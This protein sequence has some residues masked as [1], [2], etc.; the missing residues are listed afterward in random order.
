[1]K[2]SHYTIRNLSIPLL[3][4]M[5]V[6]SG[7]FYVLIMHEIDDETNDTLENYKELIIRKVLTDPSFDRNRFDEMTRYRI[8]EVPSE[9]A[10]LAANIFYDSK[11]Y[12]EIELGYEPVRVLKCYFMDAEGRYYELEIETSTLEKEDMVRTIF[13]SIIFLYFI[14]I[15]CILLVTHYVFKKSF[16]PLYGLLEWLKKIHPGKVVENYEMKTSVD[17]FI[18]LN[19]ALIESVNRNR[20]L[21]NQQKQFVENAAHELQTP[22]AVINNKLELLSENPDCTEE[23]LAEIGGIYKVLRSVIKMNKSLLLL[24]RIENKQFPETTKVNINTII[25][26]EL[27]NYTVIYANKEI[28][29]HFDEQNILEVNMNNSLARILISNLLKNAFVHN[30]NGGTIHVEIAGNDLSI[31]NTSNNRA[32]DKK[33][34]FTRFNKGD[35]SSESTGLGLA[36]IKSI[37]SLYSIMIEYEYEDNAHRFRL[38]FNC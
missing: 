24:T 5:L 23:Q 28:H 16:R 36:I 8:K 3:I 12:I 6:W 33:K 11:T 30:Y 18:T 32:L 10:D 15:C 31:S 38:H 7:I 34:L 29:I 27:E 1:M 14:L 19:K 26:S 22:L 2:L 37:T 20:E 9:E 21:Y 35:N 25:Q 4:I 13:W 17:E